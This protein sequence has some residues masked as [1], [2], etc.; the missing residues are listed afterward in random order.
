VSQELSFCNFITPGFS[1]A[2][3]TD[4][5]SCLCG[6]STI[7]GQ[8][9]GAVFDE[10]LSICADYAF[11]AQSSDYPKLTSLENF[12][13]NTFQPLS[14]KGATST[15]TSAPSTTFVSIPP[16]SAGSAA[17]TPVSPPGLS[18]GVQS[19]KLPTP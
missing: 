7:V 12:C 1:T 11:T 10:E 18:P 19:K 4:Q 14:S 15:V 2:P 3:Y 17:P 8:F 13:S 16:T 6:S 5:R 9:T